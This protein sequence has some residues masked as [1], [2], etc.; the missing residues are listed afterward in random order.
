MDSDSQR[1]SG[2]NAHYTLPALAEVFREF[3]LAA[4]ALA[5]GRGEG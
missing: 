5:A 2:L 3:R 1:P 4:E